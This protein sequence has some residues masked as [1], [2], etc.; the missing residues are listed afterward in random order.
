[1]ATCLCVLVAQ[2]DRALP[3]E[4]RGCG[5]KSRRAYLVTHMVVWWRERKWPKGQI[6]KIP[7][8]RQR[9]Q[10]RG[11]HA[12]WLRK[13]VQDDSNWGYLVRV[14]IMLAS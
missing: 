8:V 7:N 2:L 3:S 13:R 9:I 14:A 1:M 6:A 5:F 4:G 12:A 10:R 11:W